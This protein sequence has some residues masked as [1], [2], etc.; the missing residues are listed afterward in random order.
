MNSPD[1]ARFQLFEKDKYNKKWDVFLDTKDHTHLWRYQIKDK[2]EEEI[3]T[4]E[5]ASSNMFSE[6]LT[7]KFLHLSGRD[8]LIEKIEEN[9]IDN[10]FDILDL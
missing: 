8:D 3:S 1:P 10:R 2:I 5:I 6:P 4:F 9:K 7:K